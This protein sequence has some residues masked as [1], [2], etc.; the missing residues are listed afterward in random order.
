DEPDHDAL[1]ER[2]QRFLLRAIEEDIEL[3][4]SMEDAVKSLRIVLAAEESIRSGQ[5]VTL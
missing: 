4:A 3:G 5:V 1:C 2:E